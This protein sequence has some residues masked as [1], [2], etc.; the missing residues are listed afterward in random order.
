MNPAIKAGI[1]ANQYIIE[2]KDACPPVIIK[3][4]VFMANSIPIIEI[5]D[6]EKA[7]FNASVQLNSS[8]ALRIKVSKVTE[9]I[10]PA[11]MARPICQNIDVPG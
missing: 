10:N 11:I 2:L 3:S 5:N 8:L 4:V 1:S 9:V 6:I 7:V